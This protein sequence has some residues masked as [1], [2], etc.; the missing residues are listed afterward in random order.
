MYFHTHLHQT[1]TNH[2]SDKVL[3]SQMT[4]ENA[5]SLMKVMYNN[6]ITSHRHHII[7]QSHQVVDDCKHGTNTDHDHNTHRRQRGRSS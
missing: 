3:M 2:D 5:K 6:H 4:A 1:F 7:S